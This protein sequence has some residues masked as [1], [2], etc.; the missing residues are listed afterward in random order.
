MRKIDCH[1]HGFP[2]IVHRGLAASG[3]SF[4]AIPRTP[5]DAAARIT[6]MNAV[7]ID[8]ELLS[9]PHVY[10]VT[11]D[12]SDVCRELNDVFAA[13]VDAHRSRFRA[14]LHLD[15]GD[16]S[17]AIAELDRT[18]G[19]DA[20]CGVIVPSNFHGRYLDEPEFTPL[21]P[22][23][24]ELKTPVFMHPVD[25]PCYHDNEPPTVLSWPF[26]TTLALMRLITRGL[27]DRHPGLVLI[28][29]HL[30]GVL[31]FIAHR[32]DIAF[33][34]QTTAWTCARPPSS[35][36]PNLYVDTAIGWSRAAF[37]CAREQVGIEHI[38]FGTDH[39]NANLPHMKKIDAFVLNALSES[40]RTQ[41]YHAN[42]ERVFR[43]LPS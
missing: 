33:A 30:G 40:E 14:F 19:N 38:V 5:W 21:W 10:A 7:A 6:E 9:C 1:C 35:Y 34:P 25:S 16:V 26:D 31:P 41:V 17:A 4:S 32:I 24:A 36:L 22:A 18:A 28:A 42:A 3:T 43:S 23:L 39:F 37:D 15:L 13:D 27:F 20:F 11:A 29:S 8:V 2:P 12:L